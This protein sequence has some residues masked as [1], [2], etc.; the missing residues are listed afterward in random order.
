MLILYFDNGNR[1]I[2]RSSFT[3]SGI[4]CQSW[5]RRGFSLLPYRFYE[6]MGFLRRL[7]NRLIHWYPHGRAHELIVVF[8]TKIPS[9]YLRK[10][11]KHNP[12]AKIVVW[13]W[14]EIKPAEKL[15]EKAGS[16][17]VWSYS[18]SDCTQYGLRYN[19]QFYFDSIVKRHAESTKAQSPQGERGFLFMGRKKG[20][21][22]QLADIASKIREAGWTCEVEFF[23][24]SHNECSEGVI[25]TTPY[26][27]TVER[28]LGFQG[29]LDVAAAQDSGLSLRVMESM[30]FH[31]KLI[32]TNPVVAR[33]DFFDENNIY[34]WGH[35][36]KSLE[37]FL[38]LPY[39]PVSASVARYYLISAWAA[40]LEAAYGLGPVVAAATPPHGAMQPQGARPSHGADSQTEEDPQ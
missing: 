1:P 37:E 31:K 7:K 32:T 21:E 18:P 26:E 14:N 40:R 12:Q 23:E 35:S 22:Q 29:I 13:C 24:G 15:L 4:E 30:F 34:I 17:D 10:L 8:D 9:F 16:T 19:P 20:R 6:H 39:R 25:P 2:F 11:A 33:Y 36:D 38:A 28:T 5:F 3:E 27:L